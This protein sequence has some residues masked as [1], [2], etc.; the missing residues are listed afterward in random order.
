MDVLKPIFC[1]TALIGIQFTKPYLALL[2]DTTTTYE[3]L[4]TAF[5]TVYDNL[6]DNVSEKL[7]QT[8][9]DDKRFKSTF[10]KECLRECVSSC[11]SEYKKEVF[12]LL[13]I[14]LPHLAT[15]FS[16]QRGALFNFGPKANENTGTLL[17][18]FS[19]TDE[20]KQ[21]KLNRAAIHNLN[22][23]RSVGFIKC[24]IHIWG[25][26]CLESASKKLSSTKA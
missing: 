1:S 7:L 17:K 10:P 2:L 18:I 3:T 23:E 14:I 9:I 11:A 13:E 19:V 4:L 16:E 25:K 15:G 8:V 20:A 12:Q 21:R 24:K 26:Q 6:A 22:E 5:P